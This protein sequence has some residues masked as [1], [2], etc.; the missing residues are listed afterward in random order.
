MLQARPGH[1]SNAAC[2]A[3]GGYGHSG[4]IAARENDAAFTGSRRQKMRRRLFN[5]AVAGR[6]AAGREGCTARSTTCTARA[7]TRALG[8]GFD[9]LRGFL[10]TA[11]SDSTAESCGTHLLTAQSSPPPIPLRCRGVW[12]HRLLCSACNINFV[13][14]QHAPPP[15]PLTPPP[16]AQHGNRHI[17]P[18]LPL[19]R[20]APCCSA[21]L[22]A[23]PGLSS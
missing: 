19:S 15:S 5:G 23:L 4:R 18:F 7:F 17:F 22:I 1:V 11:P 12:P 16:A 10:P 2:S 9:G 21:A 13:T 3:E 6:C 20:A 14:L 8:T